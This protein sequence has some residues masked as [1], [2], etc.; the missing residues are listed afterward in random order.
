MREFI[1]AGEESYSEAGVMSSPISS[2][3]VTNAFLKIQD[4][5]TSTFSRID[6][7]KLQNLLYYA[8]AWWLA[9]KDEL[10]FEKGYM[11]GLGHLLCQIFIASSESLAEG[12]S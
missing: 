4:A 1:M 10:F 11:L 6:P 3:S 2:A 9:F 5:D 7:M 12:R 8:Q